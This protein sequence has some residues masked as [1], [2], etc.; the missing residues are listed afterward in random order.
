MINRQQIRTLILLLV[1]GLTVAC[2]GG[3]AKKAVKTTREA[4]DFT[5]VAS[6]Y[7]P[8]FQGRRTASGERFNMNALTAAHRELPFGTQLKVTHLENGKSITVT[9]NDRGPFVKGRVLDLSREAAKQI[10][11][12]GSGHAEVEATIVN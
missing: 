5:G 7:G 1:A 4:A 6:W 10:G 3:A 12:L 11:M 2:G 9:V 8:G